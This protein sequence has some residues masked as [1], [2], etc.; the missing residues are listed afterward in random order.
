[1]A[2]NIE[3]VNER[4]D[5]AYNKDIFD[6]DAEAMAFSTNPGDYPAFGALDLLVYLKA[7]FREM[8]DKREKFLRVRRKENGPK[9]G[10]FIITE[11]FELGTFTNFK[12][13][14]QIITPR[15]VSDENIYDEEDA[16][17]KC[18]KT[19]ITKAK[20]HKAKSIALPLLGASKIL[21]FKEE[22]AL[23]I[24]KS[25]IIEII[26]EIKNISVTLVLKKDKQSGIEEAFRDDR[27][28][29]RCC[30]AAKISKLCEEGKLTEDEERNYLDQCEVL[31]EFLAF[32]S[33]ERRI[34]IEKNE[35]ARIMA[36]VRKEREEFCKRN[37]GKYAPD[38][39][40][41]EFAKS[42][43]QKCLIDWLGSPPS[44]Y[45]MNLLS[46]KKSC[47]MLALI[48][49]NSED[50]VEKHSSNRG[51]LPQR[52]T[53]LAYAIATKLSRDDR[54]KLMLCLDPGSK[55]PKSKKEERIE[56][57]LN[58]F[59]D[60]D[61]PEFHTINDGLIDEYGMDMRISLHRNKSSAKEKDE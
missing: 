54:V 3:I 13:L 22:K 17:A 49:G 15:N 2:D 36:L 47:K 29:E 31:N 28:L 52:A 20:E 12:W 7:G 43:V 23:R 16:L 32:H 55:Y 11:A 45:E 6:V 58:R 5:I 44:Q 26:S 37:E 51:S 14:I 9:F 25:A 18:Y 30:M 27:S 35:N 38:K 33:H 41:D 56:E 42:M 40:Y 4:F 46:G 61:F 1:M 39:I 57:Y 10:D 48:V 34:V 21:A 53:V 19:C 24:A 8:M 59:S 50:A 60:R